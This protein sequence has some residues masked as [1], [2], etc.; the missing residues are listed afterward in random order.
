MPLRTGLALY[1]LFLRGLWGSQRESWRLCKVH[2]LALLIILSTW[3]LL[4]T[5]EAGR[6]RH[7]PALKEAFIRSFLWL[8]LSELIL[9]ASVFR[10]WFEGAI[11]P[12]IQGGGVWPPIGIESISPWGVPLLNR[13]LLLF[14]SLTARLAHQRA[15]NRKNPANGWLL[16]TIL[17]GVVFLLLQQLEYS[18]RRFTISCS[19]FGSLFYLGTGLHMRH[20]LVGTL[21]LGVSRLLFNRFYYRNSEMLSFELGLL[22]WHFVDVVWLCLWLTFY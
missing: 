12:S 6:G 2:F 5:Y 4:N 1:T 3:C 15:A 10:G 20:V 22:Y 16:L 11:S 17:L 21:W 8:I 7:L 9:F 13:G 14:R 19:R 18:N